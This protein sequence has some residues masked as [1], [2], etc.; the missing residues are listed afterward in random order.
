MS[1]QF[2]RA[3]KPQIEGSLNPHWKG[4]QIIT[5]DG[6][7]M[8]HSPQHP[9]PSK[10]KYV[11]RYRLVMEKRLGRFLVPEEIVH[12]K[13]HIN[14]DDRIENLELLNNRQH[15]QHHAHDLQRAGKWSRK[16]SACIQ[17]GKTEARHKGNGICTRCTDKNR[18]PER[19][20]R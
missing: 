19:S 12:H 1:L 4:G 15:S 5:K 14:D 11:Y 8:I 10:G 6:R 16:F 17:C 3:K 20:A 2:T 18:R 13:N 7:V 9:W